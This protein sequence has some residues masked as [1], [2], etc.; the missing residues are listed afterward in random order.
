MYA[1]AFALLALLA[2]AQAP[3]TPTAPTATPAPAEAGAAP[4]PTTP[5][6]TTTAPTTTAPTTE[7]TPTTTP[8][9]P[10]PEKTSL[11]PPKTKPRLLV[12]DIADK[13]AGADITNAVNQALQQQ[14]VLSHPGETVTA[15]QIKLLLDAQATQQLVGCDAEACMTQIGTLVEADLIL[16]GNVTRVGDDVVITVLTV[17]P[18]DGRRVK[19][20]QRK[21]PLNKDLYYYAAKQLSSLV[22]TGKA[23]DPR[24]PVV[25]QVM[26]GGVAVEGT[27]IVDGKEVGLASNKQFDVDPGAHEIMVK[28]PGFTTWRTLLDVAE[29][30]PQ[31]VSATLVAERIE[32][33]PVAVATGA[34]AVATGVA[35]L[36]MFDVAAAEYS[37]QG[38]LFKAE[39]G[40][41]QTVAP[42][43]SAD[44]CQREETIWFYAGRSPGEGEDLFATNGCGVAA[45]PGVGG[46]LGITSATLLTVTGALLTT[47]LITAALAE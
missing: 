37:G 26:A 35:A 42:T 4:A 8:A 17:D 20:E 31:Q 22:L 11:L 16:G 21:T 30:A 7:V 15:T 32:L 45:G 29:G 1:A 46:W 19:Q 23:A 10:P 18:K 13:G 33:W 24:V 41:Y 25:I 27:I 40:A 38:V 9:A 44:L 5:A 36:L 2:P 12:I 28:R 34:A 6:P 39:N 47:D 3:T 14:A 43:D